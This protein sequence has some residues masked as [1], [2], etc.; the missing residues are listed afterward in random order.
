MSSIGSYIFWV[1]FTIKTMYVDLINDGHVFH[2]KFIWKLKVPFK[3]KIFMWYLD[4]EVVLTKDNLRKHRQQG[5]TKC[6]F[7]DNY[8]SI[9]HLFLDCRL[10][11]L[12]QHTIHVAY[13]L[14][15][16]T[17]I[18]NMFRNWLLGIHPRLK[19]Q[20]HVG[21]CALVWAI[22]NFRNDCVF[23]RMKVPFFFCRLYSRLPVGSKCDPIYSMR[24]YG[25]PWTLGAVNGRRQHGSSDMDGAPVIGLVKH[26][27]SCNLIT[28][29]LF[30]PSGF[31]YPCM[32][33]FGSL[34]M[35]ALIDA[36]ASFF[37]SLRKKVSSSCNSFCYCC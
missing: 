3:I 32:R 22:W 36:E 12:L 19:A 34:N 10:A 9:Q 20:I 27:T 4:R 13:N 16:P 37:P 21:V 26:A 25:H 29:W 2:R 11:I 14:P 8:E 31:L 7:S 24:W 18:T 5:C 1:F 33:C 15:P 17:C 28:F 30:Q 6:C 35:C 23:N